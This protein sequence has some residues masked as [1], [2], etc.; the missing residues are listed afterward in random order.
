MKNR[1]AWLPRHSLIGAALV[2]LPNCG[3]GS[4]P[5]QSA[6]GASEPNQASTGAAKPFDFD[7]T[8]KREASGLKEQGVQG[9]DAAWSAKVPAAAEPKLSRS[10]NAMLVEIPI[11]SE[12]AVRCQVFGDTLDPAGTLHGV[13]K[14]SAQSVE[15]RSVAPSGVALVGGVPAA[16]LETV[17]VTE[18][19]GGKGAGGLKLAIQV[20]EQESLLC[21]HDELGYRETFKD[22]SKAFFSSFQVRNAPPS[23]NTYSDISKERI[24]DTDV[25]Y[26]WAR[27]SP[28]AKPG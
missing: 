7:A 16:F 15:Y 25:G 8:L 18:T 6:Q 11:G 17:Y 24:G 14:E 22:I 20:R 2:L 27:V 12:S 26:G 1:V 23:A 19:E 5:A 21:L 4:P 13:I 10:E 9:P 3:G 28:G